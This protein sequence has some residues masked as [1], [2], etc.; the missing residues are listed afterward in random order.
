MNS[1]GQVVGIYRDAADPSIQHGFLREP[2]GSIVTIDVPGQ[3]FVYAF[4][5]NDSGQIAG[6]YFEFLDDA[7]FLTIT[8]YLRDPGGELTFLE[9]PDAVCCTVTRG[10]DNSGRLAGWAHKEL[11][12]SS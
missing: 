4:R 8:S 2:D 11:E 7:P 9:V 3:T 5:I 10:L 12:P 1:H 6:Y